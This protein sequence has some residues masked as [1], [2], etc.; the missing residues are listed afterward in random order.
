M[1]SSDMKVQLSLTNNY[2]QSTISYLIVIF[3]NFVPEKIIESYPYK[4]YYYVQVKNV[5][6]TYGL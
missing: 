4:H 1:K 5:Y 6:W 3:K 2:Y